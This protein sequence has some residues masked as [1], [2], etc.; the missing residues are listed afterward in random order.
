MEISMFTDRLKLV[1]AASAALTLAPPAAF[2]QEPPSRP[3]CAVTSDANLPPNLAAWTT[4]TPVVAA[5]TATDLAQASLPIGKGV[6]ARLKHGGE[7]TFPVLPAKPG[8][9]VSY[10]GL[11]DLRIGEA[12]DYQVSLGTGAW[13]ELVDGKT[14]VESSAHAPGPAC[15]SLK[16][17]VVFPLKPGRYVL[18]ITGNAEPTLSVMVT[19]LAK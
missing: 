15:S 19:R 10:G 7:I 1:L 11:Y 16:K 3:A 12:G 6:D 14:L 18:E 4:R 8:G 13:I 17:T 5:A 2:A 9:S